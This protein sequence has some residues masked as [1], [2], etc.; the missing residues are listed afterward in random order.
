MKS[1]IKVYLQIASIRRPP[2][3]R[4]NQTPRSTQILALEGQSWKMCSRVSVAAKHQGQ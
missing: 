4:P 3:L 1:R 2:P